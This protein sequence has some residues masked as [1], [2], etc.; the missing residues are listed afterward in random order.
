MIQIVDKIYKQADGSEI[1]AHMIRMGDEDLLTVGEAAEAFGVEPATVRQLVLK[2]GLDRVDAIDAVVQ[3][4]KKAGVIGLRTS[5]V[6]LLPRATIDELV[7]IINTDEAKA[8]YR[9]IVGE[10]REAKKATAQAGSL[11]HMA[12]AVKQSVKASA[13][14]AELSLEV[15]KRVDAIA[16][17]VA[18]VQ[19]HVEDSLMSSLEMSELQRA[20]YRC[21]A[22]VG[23]KPGAIM[24]EIKQR[25]LPKKL[26]GGR[27]WKE[28]SRAS[29]A[30]ALEFCNTWE[31]LK[32]R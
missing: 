12:E 19:Q 9:Q 11:E 6:N 32:Y 5:T 8:A 3:E 21:S 30:D 17:V 16:T 20:I 31:P 15:N 26:A 25:F 7:R 24:R 28:I 27:T 23:F 2:H 13:G 4:L 29:F 1:T 22:R 10:W 18:A 14:A